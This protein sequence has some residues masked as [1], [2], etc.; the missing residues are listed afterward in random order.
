ME[1]Y[2]MISDWRINIIRKTILLKMIY[3][4]NAIDEIT[5]YISITKTN[6]LKVCI[7]KHKILR[8]AKAILMKKNKVGNIILPDFRQCYKY[9]VIKTVWCLH[10]YTY[11]DTQTDKHTHTQKTNGLLKWSGEAR[12]KTTH[13]YMLS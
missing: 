1:R 7:W 11:T 6:N 9:T 2:L 13:P 4:F 5:H 3:T 12:N 8:N 10:T